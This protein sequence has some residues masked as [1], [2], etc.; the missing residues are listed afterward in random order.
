MKSWEIEGFRVSPILATK[1]LQAIPSLSVGPDGRFVEGTDGVCAAL[2]ADWLSKCP[3][4]PVTRVDQLRSRQAI[5]LMQTAYQL[6]RIG[7]EGRSQNAAILHAAGVEDVLLHPPVK[8]RSDMA[9][10]LNECEAS[11]DSGAGFEIGIY[12]REGRGAHSVG[13]WMFEA[14]MHFFD[15]NGGIVK[16]PRPQR[17]GDYV[18]AYLRRWYPDFAA[19]VSLR[20]VR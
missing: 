18:C 16:L 9:A 5:S 20:I 2:V 11:G 12:G 7:S 3:A 1:A 13:I 15:P 17:M 8:S 4:G 19:R 6:K 14:E 10:F